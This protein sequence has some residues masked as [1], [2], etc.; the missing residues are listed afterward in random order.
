MTAF[1]AS[2][3]VGHRS[4]LR[5]RPRSQ[6]V[7]LTASR[8]TAGFLL[9][10]RANASPGEPQQTTEGLFMDDPFG[11]FKGQ[12]RSDTSDS[13]SKAGTRVKMNEKQDIFVS[14]RGADESRAVDVLV[15]PGFPCPSF[16]TRNFAD[17]LAFLQPNARISAIDWPGVG[18]V[19]S[20]RQ[21]R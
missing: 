17:R 11:G 7:S 4:F 12:R 1:V 5:P 14:V 8:R 13:W 9:C 3:A 18:E 21:N 2:A 16:L 20:A 15:F 19:R 10:P 6:L